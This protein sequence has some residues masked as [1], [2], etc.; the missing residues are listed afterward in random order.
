MREQKNY[1]HARATAVPRRGKTAH[2]HWF[3]SAS[4]IKLRHGLNCSRAVPTSATPTPP[5]T[6]SQPSTFI[7]IGGPPGHGDSVRHESH[8]LDGNGSAR[9]DLDRV[10]E[11]A[12][13]GEVPPG[14]AFLFLRSAELTMLYDSA[15]WW[16]MFQTIWHRRWAMAQMAF[17]YPSLGMSRRNN[18]C[19]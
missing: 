11:L 12:Q 14:A 13:F 17:K 2:T 6:L 15:P 3:K 19:R 4:R 10:A 18:A 16:R 1:A 9:D 8:P 7:L 5:S